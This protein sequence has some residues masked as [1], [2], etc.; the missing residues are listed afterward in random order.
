VIVAVLLVVG[1]PLLAVVLRAL[2]RRGAAVEAAERAARPAPR[3]AGPDWP[4]V[5]QLYRGNVADWE[6]AARQQRRDAMP[7][8]ASH[9]DRLSEYAERQARAADHCHR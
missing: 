4:V 8:A 6:L 7:H 5:A 1:G 9:S 2:E 3:P